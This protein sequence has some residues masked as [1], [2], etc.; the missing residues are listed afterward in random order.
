MP[1]PDSP[2]IRAHRAPVSLITAVFCVTVLALALSGRVGSDEGRLTYLGAQIAADDLAAG[3]FLQKLHPALSLLYLP[4]VALGWNAFAVAHV[5]LAALGV[6]A[7]GRWVERLGGD[8]WL[9]ALTVAASPAYWFSAATGQSNSDGLALL[10]VGLWLYEGDTRRQRF[11]AGVVLGLTVW[12]R[13]EFAAFVGVLVLVALARP[14]RREAVLGALVFPLLYLSAGAV[15]H[16]AP[17]W[18]LQNPPMES[19]PPPGLADV[20]RLTPNAENILRI[21]SA[22]ALVAGT[23]ALLFTPAAFARGGSARAA[24]VVSAA[25]LLA[26]TV[27]PFFGIDGPEVAPRY[28]SIALPGIA[29][30]V[31][32]TREATLHRALAVAPLAVAAAWALATAHV[33]PMS[34]LFA[35]AALAMLAP[36][37]AAWLRGASRAAALAALALLPTVTVAV[38]PTSL[39][40]FE[41]VSPPAR[42]L[43]AVLRA[44]AQQRPTLILTNVQSL[45]PALAASWAGPARYI[46]SFD[47]MLGLHSLS[48]H[49]NGQYESVIRGI[50][51][52]YET[53]G[54]FWPCE[55]SGHDF[56]AGD[57]VVLGGDARPR[58]LVPDEIWEPHTELV[59]AFGD[60]TIR[61]FTTGPVRV[62][63]PA[64]PAW[65]SPHIVEAPCRALAR[66]PV[67]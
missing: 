38:A 1:A 52:H 33:R 6:L 34:P 12:A 60:V 42:A 15:Y 35:L 55:L 18:F 40:D 25:L 37:V 26:F 29:I 48:N 10:A 44:A 49:R 4:T 62:R 36:A 27:S 5:L 56:H 41:A 30:A 28:L 16:H 32:F 53:G 21:F 2:S 57:L 65:L 24:A 66:R 14:G 46:P 61:R 63:L 58:L 59:E 47:V 51:S 8:G 3:L 9:A 11:A 50:S 23:W 13:Y 39:R 7:V 43:A 22:Y 64:P 67:E 54:M 17:L 31:A 45:T 20:F 19:T